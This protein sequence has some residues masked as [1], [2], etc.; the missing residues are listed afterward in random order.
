MR[1]VVA[2]AAVGV[3]AAPPLDV[4]AFIALPLAEPAG[5][6][7]GSAPPGLDVQISGRRL[8]DVIGDL[9][10]RSGASRQPQAVR[11]PD[12]LARV[13]ALSALPPRTGWTRTGEGTAAELRAEVASAV[14]EFRAQAP[15]SASDAELLPLAEQIWDAPAWSGLPLRAL[16]AAR[17]FNFLSHPAQPV[18]AAEQGNWQRLSTPRGQVFTRGGASVMT[19]LNLSVLR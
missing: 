1:L 7:P 14:Q 5:A 9:S 12:E 11:L 15:A 13:P 17:L 3:Y 10:T 4:L 19:G 6:T 18:F 8:R 2:E 16:H